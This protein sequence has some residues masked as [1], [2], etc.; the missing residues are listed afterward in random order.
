MGARL[1]TETIVFTN[2]F[3]PFKLENVGRANTPVRQWHS[4][5]WFVPPAFLEYHPSLLTL[6]PPPLLLQPPPS[7]NCVYS[8]RTLSQVLP[9]GCFHLEIHLEVPS[10]HYIQN[11]GHHSLL[12]FLMLRSW[13]L[14]LPPPICPSHRWELSVSIS[15]IALASMPS[16]WFFPRPLIV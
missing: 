8:P 9:P 14:E 3:F 7:P 4:E 1:R 13:L 10:T 16:S 2:T 11:R 5:A 12:G 15:E 6:Q